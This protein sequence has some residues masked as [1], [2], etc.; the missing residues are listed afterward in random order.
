MKE[1]TEYWI[2]YP[3]KIQVPLNNEDLLYESSRNTSS[4]STIGEAITI[5]DYML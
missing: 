4:A 1:I 3:E 5:N 2:V